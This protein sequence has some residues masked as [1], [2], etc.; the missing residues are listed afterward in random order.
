MGSVVMVVQA[1]EE[2]VAL[3][4]KTAAVEGRNDGE[5]RRRRTGDIGGTQAVR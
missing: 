4:S 5:V 1:R 3:R 2:G